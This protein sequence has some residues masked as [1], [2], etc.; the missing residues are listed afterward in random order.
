MSCKLANINRKTIHLKIE[1]KMKKIYTCLPCETLTP[2][3]ITLN[4]HYSNYINNF[5]TKGSTSN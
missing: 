5:N 1:E 3:H 2:L 4:P